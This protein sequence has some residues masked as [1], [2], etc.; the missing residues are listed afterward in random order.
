[1]VAILS[2]EQLETQS[3]SQLKK[4]VKA[5]QQAGYPIDYD[6]VKTSAQDAEDVAKFYRKKIRH[7][8]RTPPAKAKSPRS[9]PVK[10]EYSG[11]AAEL[12]K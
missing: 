7:A 11:R 9:K 12:A 5:L 10:K 8:Q 3:V 6:S 1:M 2:N 4:H